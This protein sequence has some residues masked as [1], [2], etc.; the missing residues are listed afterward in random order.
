MTWVDE[1]PWVLE[2]DAAR[3]LLPPVLLG[4]CSEA[5]YLNLLRPSF[6]PLQI[7]T[8]MKPLQFPGV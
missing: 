4:C 3:F 1:Q 5:S 2:S 7:G 8:I 6:L